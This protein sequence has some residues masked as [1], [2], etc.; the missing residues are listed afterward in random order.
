MIQLD[1]AGWRVQLVCTP[2]ALAEAAA[3]RYAPF[4]KAVD[5]PSDLVMEVKAGL[6]KLPV[7]HPGSVQAASLTLDGAG[8]RLAARGIAGSV[9]ITEGRAELQL[10]AHEPL[11][12][13]EYFLRIACALLAF[14]RGGLLL[15]SAG[16]VVGGQAYL[17]TGVSGSGK[18]TVTALSPHATALSDDLVLLRPN[19]TG[20][21]AHGTPF[22]NPEAASRAGQTASGPV[23]GIYK[24]VKAPHV[25]LETL[26]FAAAAAELAANCP[27]VNGRPELLPELLARCR[28]LAAATPVQQLH[29]RK[30]ASFWEVV[31]RSGG[32]R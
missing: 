15:H 28:T 17:F 13:L 32:S 19:N 22:W 21:I 24:L 16:L 6:A 23:A 10:N 30:E 14:Q 31:N 11:G 29:F 2:D 1:L 8:Y 7:A 9:S 27:V 26:S 5:S 3:A 20:W 25:R 12:H 18:S 4:A